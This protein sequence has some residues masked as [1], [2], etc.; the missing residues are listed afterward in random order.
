M[1]IIDLHRRNFSGV[2]NTFIGGVAGIMPDA[3][4]MASLLQI[5]V[6]SISLF[7]INSGNVKAN[8]NIYYNLPGAL[9]QNYVNRPGYKGY[10][11][12]VTYYKDPEGKVKQQGGNCFTYQANLMEIDF[13]GTTFI[14]FQN[15]ENCNLQVAIFPVLEELRTLHVFNGNNNNSLFYAPNLI[16]ANSHSGA[17]FGGTKNIYIPNCTSFTP[18]QSVNDGF[19]SESPQGVKIWVHPLLQ[20]SNN[21]AEETDLAWA[22]AN[23]A[24]IIDY[25]QPVLTP[26][27]FGI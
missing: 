4:T 19:F 16:L 25:S 13:P 1:R 2:P 5:P 3:S 21:G 15:F 27:D 14:N 10:G 11:S 22:R 17:C 12:I 26:N 7:A 6:D 8:I 9:F 20:T 24:A 18:S 23:K